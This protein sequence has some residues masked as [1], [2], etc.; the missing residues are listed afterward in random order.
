MARSASDNSSRLLIPMASSGS[1]TVTVT[2]RP[3][4]ASRFTASVR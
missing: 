1:V 4:W 2:T 3:S